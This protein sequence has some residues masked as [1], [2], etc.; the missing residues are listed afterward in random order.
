MKVLAITQARVGSSRLPAKVLKKIQGNTLLDIHLMR[1][2]QAKRIDQIV[3]ATTLED[4]SEKICGIAESQG[5]LSFQ[6]SMNDVLDR[7]YQAAKIYQPEWVLR[8]TSDCPLLDPVLIDEIIKLAIDG[9]YDYCSNTLIQDFPD[10]QD[11]EICK[12]GV[13]EKAWKSASL[14]SDREHVTPFI[15]ANSD[16]RG[17]LLFSACDYKAP[18]N[19]NHVR[20]TVDEQLDFEMMKWLIEDLGLDKTWLDYTSHIMNNPSMV[21]NSAIIRNEGYLKSLKQDNQI[22]M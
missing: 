6:G 15:Q 7:F 9:N 21:K 3:V 8:V 5:V 11:I 12:I 13:L 19:Y 2:K 14:A 17:G 10:G 22:E 18:E 1:L 16:L 4:D 20:M